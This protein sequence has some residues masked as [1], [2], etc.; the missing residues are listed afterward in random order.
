MK[1]EPRIEEKRQYNARRVS[2]DKIGAEHFHKRAERVI[3]RQKRVVYHIE[4]RCHSNRESGVD[5]SHKHEHQE[6]NGEERTK[7]A[8]SAFRYAR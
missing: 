3:R 5:K 7:H 4:Q 8:K 6:L 2:D 1:R